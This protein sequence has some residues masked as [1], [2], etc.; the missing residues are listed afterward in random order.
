MTSEE[1][2]ALWDYGDPAESERRFR[3]VG[4][5]EAMTQVARAIGLQKRFEEAH[6]LLDEL[7]SDDPIVVARSILERGRLFR[8]SG[9]KDAAQEQFARAVD[10]AKQIDADFYAVDAAHMIA[11]CKGDVGAHYSAIDLAAQSSDERAQ[12]WEAS[13]LNNLG[14]T[15]FDQG[16]H[17]DALRAFQRALTAREK[18]GKP[19]E[20]VIAQWC[21]ARCLRELGRTE[22][23][24]EI[25]YELVGADDTGFASEEVGECLFALGRESA[26]RPY[27]AEAC[28]RLM[29][30]DDKRRDRIC[31][32]GENSAFAEILD[33]GIKLTR[34]FSVEQSSIW[35]LIATKQGLAQWLGLINAELARG[36]AFTLRIEGDENDAME[37]EV[38]QMDGSTLRLRWGNGSTLTFALSE[39]ALELTHEGIDDRATYGAAWHSSLDLIAHIVGGEN[40]STFKENYAELLPEYER[41]ISRAQNLKTR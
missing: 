17:I 13:L 10:A 31:R 6:A 21:V 35:E 33:Q 32:L 15:L 34:S 11:I 30:F 9:D 27:F 4:T 5:P 26:A 36:K 29:D 12:A 25:Q 19:R 39:T 3:Q 14:W 1:L 41:L 20:T 37:C 40:R 22:E 7:A 38:L 28:F 2:D 24:L 18:Q 16:K 8:D 23:A